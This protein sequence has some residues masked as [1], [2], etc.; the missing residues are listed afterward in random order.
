MSRSVLRG[1]VKR[2][3]IKN[4]YWKMVK[5]SY[6]FLKNAAKSVKSQNI[7]DFNVNLLFLIFLTNVLIA[8]PFNL[9]HSRFTF[10]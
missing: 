9:S 4:K 10:F 3:K 8:Q 7:V 5:N 2:I 1:L 6:E